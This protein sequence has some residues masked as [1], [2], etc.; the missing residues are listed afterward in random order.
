M[1]ILKQA[2]IEPTDKI[3]EKYILIKEVGKGAFGSVYEAK[4]RSSQRK[5]AIKKLFYDRKYEQREVPTLE[6]IKVAN[7]C[8]NIISLESHFL[9]R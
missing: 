8:G 5:V 9:R 1:D 6:E 2:G 7:K 3:C 4:E